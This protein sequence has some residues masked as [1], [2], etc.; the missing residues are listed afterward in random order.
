MGNVLCSVARRAGGESPVPG[1]RVTT[2]VCAWYYKF[3]SRL[4]TSRSV[5]PLGQVPSESSCAE[6]KVH[7]MLGLVGSPPAQLARYCAVWE[8]GGLQNHTAPLEVPGQVHKHRRVP[9]A[10]LTL[11]T[12]A[13]SKSMLRACRR[14]IATAGFV[15]PFHAS[16]PRLLDD[17]WDLLA[18]VNS[19]STETKTTSYV[20]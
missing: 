16:A 4:I 7:T 9:C 17:D 12:E 10:S 19:V 6:G 18:G 3:A 11:L 13:L 8:G 2:P 14:S 1:V 5:L 20:A 15:R